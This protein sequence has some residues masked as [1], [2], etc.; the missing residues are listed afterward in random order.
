MYIVFQVQN[1]PKWIIQFDTLGATAAR[2]QCDGRE[3]LR[4]G[5]DT[6]TVIGCLAKQHSSHLFNGFFGNLFQWLC[7]SA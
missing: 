3:T 1:T 7:P 4:S 5:I 2:T 6:A